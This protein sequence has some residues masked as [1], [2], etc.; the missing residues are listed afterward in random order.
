[1]NLETISSMEFK[2]TVL[3]TVAGVLVIGS[4]FVVAVITAGCTGFAAYIGQLCAKQVVAW[5][6]KK[7][8][9]K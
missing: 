3:G 4:G 9:T 8:A 6:Q 2:S 1:M 5:W 7:R